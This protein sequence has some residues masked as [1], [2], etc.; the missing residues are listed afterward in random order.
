MRRA[1]YFKCTELHTGKMRASDAGETR[2]VG[3]LKVRK[4]QFGDAEL[5]TL[6]R[7]ERFD[8]AVLSF[9]ATAR[10]T[11]SRARSMFDIHRSS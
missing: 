1:P 5:E 8:R 4:T 6:F 11:F 7:D 9:K 10:N 2:P 3:A